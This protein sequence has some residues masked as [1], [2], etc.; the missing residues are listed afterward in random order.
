VIVYLVRHAK[1]GSRS[2]WTDDDGLRPLSAKGRRQADGLA[3]R[4][5][6]LAIDRLVSSPAVRCRQTLEPLAERIGTTVEN[7]EEMAEGAPTAPALALLA[8]LTTD[9]AV[10]AHGDLIPRIVEH[11]AAG[12]LLLEDPQP[13]QK[14]GTWTL[15]RH[16]GRFVVGRYTPPP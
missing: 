9:T 6:P 4:L 7:A 14:A 11:L 5:A 12:G 15:E 16:D 1:A 13:C 2:A 10:S 3:D 8:T